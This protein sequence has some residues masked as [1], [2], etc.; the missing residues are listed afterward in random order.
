[1]ALNTEESPGREEILEVTQHARTR[2]RRWKRRAVYSTF[3]LL[4]NCAAIV[5]CLE[6]H[7]LHRCWHSFGRCLILVAMGVTLIFTYCVGLFWGALSQ[8]RE[9][10]RTYS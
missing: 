10:E 7:S 1:M 3:A 2:V 5:P 6:G 9:L 4:L 8:L